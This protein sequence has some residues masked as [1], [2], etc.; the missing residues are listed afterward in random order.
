MS[1]TGFLRI[2]ALVCIMYFDVK[3][4]LSLVYHSIFNT[5]IFPGKLFCT[6]MF[7]STCHGVDNVL[8]G[9]LNS[10]SLK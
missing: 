2:A 4:A 1:V 10:R 7:N 6:V 9:E 3:P 5:F 8:E